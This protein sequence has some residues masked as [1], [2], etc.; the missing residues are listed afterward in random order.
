MLLKNKVIVIGLILS[1]F[2]GSAFADVSKSHVKK[3]E[4]LLEVVHF[5][6][7]I[8]QQK[9]LFVNMVMKE[10][11]LAKHKKEFHQLFSEILNS[12]SLKK[13]MIKSYTEVFTEE[14]ID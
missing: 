14:E 7:L 4:K 12:A 13:N 11:S 2:A 8:E 5:D 1:L 6:K 3:V 9:D 10:P